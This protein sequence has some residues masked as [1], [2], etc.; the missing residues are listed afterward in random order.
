[1]KSVSYV[2]SYW[3][4][5]IFFKDDAPLLFYAQNNLSFYLLF[6]NILRYNRNKIC[7]NKAF[8][9]SLQNIFLK[10]LHDYNAFIVFWILKFFQIVCLIFYYVRFW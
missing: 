9:F 3:E 1:M 7:V 8:I 2:K 10:M 5:I 4:F 6:F